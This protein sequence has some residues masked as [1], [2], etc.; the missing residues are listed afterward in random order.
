MYLNFLKF[1][2]WIYYYEDSS[3][4]MVENEGVVKSLSVIKLNVRD[5]L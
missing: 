1:Y 3:E 2:K 5:S 4:I